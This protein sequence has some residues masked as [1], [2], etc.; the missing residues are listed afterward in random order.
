[1]VSQMSWSPVPFFDRLNEAIC[2]V[3]NQITHC[4]GRLKI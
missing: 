2:G 3:E 1:M 4:S